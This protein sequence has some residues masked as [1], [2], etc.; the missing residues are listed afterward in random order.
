MAMLITRFQKLIQSKVLWYFILGVIIVS[1]VGFFM[2]T[3]R[4]GAR[5]HDIPPVGE[6][7]GKKVPQ[8]EYRRA[9]HNSY[10]WYILSSGRMIPMTDELTKALKREAWQRVAV[11]HKAKSEEILVA[12]AEVVRQMQAMP[13]FQA[14]NGAFDV[15]IYKA[16]LQQIGLTPRQAEE[17][18]R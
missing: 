16:V 3:N 7:F 13:L 18:F 8:D 4:A 10:M 2:P 9:Y 1:F 5:T 12:D 11:L 15:N 6:L 17:L 14:K